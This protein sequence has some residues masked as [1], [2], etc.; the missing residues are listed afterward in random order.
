MSPICYQSAV[1]NFYF[2]FNSIISLSFNTCSSPIFC[3][4]NLLEGPHTFAC[5]IF[6]D[7]PFRIFSLASFSVEFIFRIIG[8]LLGSFLG[9]FVYI[10]MIGNVLNIFCFSFSVSNFF[11][12]WQSIIM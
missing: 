10:L 1:I 12:F 8:S 3:P 11:G 6:F 2:V 9:S 5:V 7:I 4:P